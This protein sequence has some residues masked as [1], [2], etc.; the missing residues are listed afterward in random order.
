M[1]A[2]KTQPSPPELY[3][4]DN[5]GLLEGVEYSFNEDNSI[6]WRAMI[7]DEF[8]YP[9][10]DWFS[11]RDREIPESIEGLKDHQLLIKLGGIK[12]LAKLRGFSDVS[13]IPFRCEDDHVAVTCRIRWIGNYETEMNPV[14][15]EDIANATVRNT[16]GFAEKFLETIAA[17]RA[18]IRCVR[19]FLNIHIVGADEIDKS[20]GKE[21]E[22]EQSSAIVS[23]VAALEK[24]A[25]T[26]GFDSYELFK[27]FLRKLWKE[28]KFQDEDVK[29]WTKFEDIPPNKARKILE[30]LKEN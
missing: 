12:E 14:I 29:N 6:N 30:F 9:N 25:S 11:K 3:K 27:P 15:Y 23:A 19:N 20:E 17:N 18:F 5:F 8:L 2:K 21:V 4:R 13:Y 1:P 22:S 28:E 24:E 7:K 16:D 26:R 10:K